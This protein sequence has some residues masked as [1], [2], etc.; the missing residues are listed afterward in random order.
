[1]IPLC[2]AVKSLQFNLFVVTTDA[3]GGVTLKNSTE[4]RIE[5]DSLKSVH[6]CC[7]K[8]LLKEFL[9]L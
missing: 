6:K 2:R 3:W 7:L 4:A 5:R 8:I 1:M 9:R